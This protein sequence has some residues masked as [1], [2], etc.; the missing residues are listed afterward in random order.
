MPTRNRFLALLAAAF[1]VGMSQISAAQFGVNLVANPSAEQFTMITPGQTT[2]V[3]NFPGWTRIGNVYRT[4]YAEILVGFG[5][6]V[7]LRGN[8]YVL[9]GNEALTRLIQTVDLNFAALEISSGVAEAKISAWLGGF[10]DQEDSAEVIVRFLGIGGTQIE[11]ASLGPVTAAMRGLQ[12]GMVFR[13]H[14]MRVPPATLTAEVEIRFERFLGTWSNGSADLIELSLI[15]GRSASPEV[16]TPLAG[17]WLGGTLASLA[18]SDDDRLIILNDEIQANA[19]FEFAGHSPSALPVTGLELLL[20]H[21]STRSDLTLFVQMFNYQTQS[22]MPA[23]SMGTSGEDV[24]ASASAPGP[25]PQFV[26]PNGELKARVLWTPFQDLAA[27][28]GWIESLD[29]VRWL[30]RH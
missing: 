23:F 11:T 8:S 19:N 24:S 30:V 14:A 15:R 2:G 28:D 6:S 3:A 26:G 12:T 13:D 18:R 7:A 5:P 22:F 9:G 20:E 16:A 4:S 1:G 25:A 27:F 29:V 10:L 21:S 17:I